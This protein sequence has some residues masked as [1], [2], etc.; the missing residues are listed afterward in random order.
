MGLSHLVRTV[1]TLNLWYERGQNGFK[2]TTIKYGDFR[3]LVLQLVT[4][5][6]KFVESSNVIRIDQQLSVEDS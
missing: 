3:V 6:P 2:Q 5:T 4:L 1:S